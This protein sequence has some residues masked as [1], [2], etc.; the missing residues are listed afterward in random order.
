MTRTHAT[1]TFAGGMNGTGVPECTFVYHALPGGEN[2]RVPKESTENKDP[3]DDPLKCIL[4]CTYNGLMY[5]KGT[6]DGIDGEGEV[7]FKINGTW[8]KD[9]VKKTS[10]SWKSIPESGVGAFKDLKASGGYEGAA[11]TMPC[12]IQ[13]D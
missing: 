4:M 1:H 10:A 2:K 3:Q 6:I 12:W 13:L 5:Y 7:V 8:G 11:H 9:G